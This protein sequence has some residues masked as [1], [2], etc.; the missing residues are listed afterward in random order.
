MITELLLQDD[1]SWNPNVH[2]MAKPTSEQTHPDTVYCGHVVS[3]AGAKSTL[4]LG[5]NSYTMTGMQNS[6]G[7]FANP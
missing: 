3:Q 6:L 7:T 1:L 2:L 4:L 5:A